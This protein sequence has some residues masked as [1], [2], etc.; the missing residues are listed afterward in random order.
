VRFSRARKRYERQGVLVE[1]TALER[2]EEERLEDAD[3]RARLREREELHR[4]EQD[5][6]LVERMVTA[7]LRFFPACPPDEARKI[8]EH[9]AVRGSGRVRR[10]AAGQSLEEGALTAAVIAHVRHRHTR[11]DELLMAS[12]DRDDARCRVREVIDRVLDRWRA[13]HSPIRRIHGDTSW[14]LFHPSATLR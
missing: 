5:R 2:A 6:A 14:T 11:Y 3:R 12:S 9:T 10:T 4:A 1:E 8:A 7:I 13:A